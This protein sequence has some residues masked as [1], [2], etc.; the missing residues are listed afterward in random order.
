MRMELIPFSF[1]WD[2]HRLAN[3][4]MSWI[5][6]IHLFFTIYMTGIIW[7]VQ[8][9]HY[10]L[11]SKIGEEVFPLYEQQHQNRI[12]YIVGF[13]MLIE[14]FT[15]GLLLW[16]QTYNPLQW[17]NVTLLI[18]I[19]GSTFFIQS[20]LHGKLGNE[21]RAEWQQKLVN[22]NWIRTMAWTLRSIILLSMLL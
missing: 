15:G 5:F 22:T 16:Q 18:I 6:I 3:F 13:Q 10:P 4:I 9:V 8:I 14:L 20:P 11:M 21:Y 12:F 1:Y 17:W 2:F 19:W 7:F